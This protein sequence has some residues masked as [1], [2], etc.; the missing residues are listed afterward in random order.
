MS[1]V[2]LNHLKSSPSGTGRGNLGK[3]KWTGTLKEVNGLQMGKA[4]C[5]L[6]TVWHCRKQIFYPSVGELSE[7]QTSE[8]SFQSILPR[9]E[10]VPPWKA[11][12]KPQ[13]MCVTQSG[14]N[15]DAYKSLYKLSVGQVHTHK[16]A[17]MSRAPKRA[18]EVESNWTGI[19]Q[20][21]T[22]DL[23]HPSFTLVYTAPRATSTT[24]GQIH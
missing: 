22:N 2:T 14:H 18:I 20:K 6:V 7:N 19:R 12:G 15:H 5:T 21:T 8:S 13:G 11:S 23:R 10:H 9:N 16:H 17:F 3:S 1:H 24:H 4:A